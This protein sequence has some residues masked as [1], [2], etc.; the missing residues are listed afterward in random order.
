MRYYWILGLG[1]HLF[2]KVPR[3]GD[4]EDLCGLRVK[5]PPVTTSLTT[6]G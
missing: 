4:S 5:L 2:V 6:H 3:P 1:N